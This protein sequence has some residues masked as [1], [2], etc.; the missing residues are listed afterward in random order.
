[1]G[2][3]AEERQR[4]SIGGR[5]T[6]AR[7]RGPRTHARTH[8]KCPD[9]S[10]GRRRGG[11]GCRIPSR[12]QFAPVKKPAVCPYSRGRPRRSIGHARAVA[13]AEVGR[14]AFSLFLPLGGGRAGAANL[15]IRRGSGG[16]VRQTTTTTTALTTTRRGGCCHSAAASIKAGRGRNID[17][18]ARKSPTPLPVLQGD[19]CVEKG[20]V[21]TPNGAEWKGAAAETKCSWAPS[22][23]RLGWLGNDRDPGPIVGN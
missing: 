7:A 17:P 11:L 12:Q 8:A 20:S 13:A 18:R 3:L 15:R 19:G 4:R 14:P 1:V 21:E 23:I 6:D 5:A 22:L 10:L 2:G 16:C 9:C